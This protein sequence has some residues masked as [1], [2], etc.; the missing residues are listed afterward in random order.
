MNLDELGYL[1]FFLIFIS[2]TLVAFGKSCL[3]ALM[4]S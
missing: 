3:V 2:E 4:Q 1:S